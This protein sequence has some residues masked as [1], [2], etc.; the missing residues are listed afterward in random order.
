MQIFHDALT[1]GKHSCYLRPDCML[2]MMYIDDCLQSL[3][4]IMIAPDD[5][6]SCR[7]Y[8]VAAMSFNPEMILKEI[9]KHVPELQIEYKVDDR[10][11][12]G[13]FSNNV[14]FFCN[15][16]LHTQKILQLTNGLKYLMTRKPDRTGDG[17]MITISNTW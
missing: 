4:S 8:N 11:K 9:R 2:P 12:I 16:Y 10:Q 6:L 15:L 3:H 14:R 13:I 5:Q 7:V 1:S 17:N